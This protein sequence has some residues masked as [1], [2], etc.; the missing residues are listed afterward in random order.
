MKKKAKVYLTNGNQG[1]FVNSD[2]LTLPYELSICEHIYEIV[3]DLNYKFKNYDI[4]FYHNEKEIGIL[5]L[6]QSYNNFI[7]SEN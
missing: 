4:T 6:E 3:F 5:D 2:I 7:E 1:W